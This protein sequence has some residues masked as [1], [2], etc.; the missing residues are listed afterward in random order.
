MAVYNADKH[1][2]YIIPIPCCAC[3]LRHKYNYYHCIYTVYIIIVQ[4]YVPKVSF[5]DQRAKVLYTQGGE[6]ALVQTCLEQSGYTAGE[7]E[8]VTSLTVVGQ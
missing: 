5:Q 8:G 4:L 2:H 3:A 7:L 6:T 1:A